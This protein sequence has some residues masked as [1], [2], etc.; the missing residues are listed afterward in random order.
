MKFESKDMEVGIDGLGFALYSP[1]NT[2][3]I[4][5]ESAF[6]KMNFSDHKI[7]KDI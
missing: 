3:D 4:P 6:F 7:L 5:L 2:K 1:D